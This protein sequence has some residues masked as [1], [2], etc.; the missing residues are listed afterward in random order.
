[1]IRALVG[2]SC[3]LALG[4]AG[5]ALALSPEALGA[6]EGEVVLKDFRFADGE[7][8]PQLRMHYTTLGTP[9][10]DKAGHVTNA[11]MILHGTGGDGH[12]F[13][14]PQF[15]DVL[16]APGGLL[17]P[18]RYFIILP[19]GIGHG[20]SSKPSDGLHA[21]FPHYD[22]ADMVEA[23][24]RVATEGLK[25]DR[26]RLVMGTS[27]GCMHIFVLT[28]AHPDFVDAAMPLAC[29]PTALVG[30]NRL[31]R[32][33]SIDAIQSDPA[34]MGGEYK[35]QPAA[36]LKLAQALSTI[37]G[38]APIQMQKA[39][40]TNEAAEAEAQAVVAQRWKGLD[41]NDYIYQLDAS[42]TYDP[43]PGLAKIKVPLMWVNSA[44]D[45]INP[46]DL[47]LAEQLAPRIARGRFVLIPSSE[48]THGHG[49][50]TWAAVWKDYLK[51]LLEQS[52]R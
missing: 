7:T 51:A 48:A 11:V 12:Q 45:F 14:R 38:S 1:M 13:F 24:R 49:T 22:Y 4:W 46:P 25:V 33:I 31:W 5:G 41:A 17:D 47:G 52:A 2:L 50:H 39:F 20:R 32:R 9:I 21:K 40:P 18:A 37:V 27:M 34:Y 30:R 35:E 26:L 10:R 19:D 6:K 3:A 23:E 36:G 43:S 8:L 28:E 29:V 16:F 15:S 44:D 42:R